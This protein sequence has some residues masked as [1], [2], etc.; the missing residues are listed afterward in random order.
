[1]SS[2]LYGARYPLSGGWFKG[3]PKKKQRILVGF[4]ACKTGET[5]RIQLFIFTTSLQHG[6][7]CPLDWF[8][9]NCQTPLCSKTDHRVFLNT[10]LKTT[11][12]WRLPFNPRN[13]SLPVGSTRGRGWK[14]RNH[15]VELALYLKV[16]KSTCWVPQE[17]T[18]EA[19]EGVQISPFSPLLGFILELLAELASSHGERFCN[20]AHLPMET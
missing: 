12:N 13:T 18:Q 5:H 8:C 16:D 1:M 9:G 11:K 2:V 14:G 4:R 7:I 20:L 10:R 3:R 6:D 15:G 19:H 17:S